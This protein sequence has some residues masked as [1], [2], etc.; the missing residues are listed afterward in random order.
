MHVI[1]L[2]EE[3]Q[4]KEQAEEREGKIENERESG[5]EGARRKEQARRVLSA[6]EPLDRKFLID[7]RA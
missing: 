3:L 5:R 4:Q 6:A 7:F 2:I 1:K